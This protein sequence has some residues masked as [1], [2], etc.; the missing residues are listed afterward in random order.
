[1]AQITSNI[2]S[3]FL[4]HTPVI[5]FRTKL[6]DAQ[7]L[8]WS[9]SEDSCDSGSSSA[10]DSSRSDSDSGVSDVPSSIRSSGVSDSSSYLKYIA[11]QRRAPPEYEYYPRSCSWS[12]RSRPWM[13]TMAGT[14]LLQLLQMRR[15]SASTH[16]YNSQRRL[17]RHPA[18]HI[19]SRQCAGRSAN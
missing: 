8:E 7:V 3:D 12:A 10:P 13:Q 19:D 4:P 16:C 1:M 9:S 2:V 17:R 5:A 18:T 11:Y 14:A 15:F 6:Q